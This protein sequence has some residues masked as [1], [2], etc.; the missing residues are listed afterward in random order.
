MA[1]LGDR[2]VI[3]EPP[4]L[5]RIAVRLAWSMS[6][7][8]TEPGPRRDTSSDDFLSTILTPGSSLNPK[9]LLVVDGVLASLALIL[10]SL[11]VASGGSLHPIALLLIELAL[12]VSI[13]W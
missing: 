9:F 12:W 2:A 8:H 3:S 1:V 6:I 4:P 10:V 5:H 11:I 7:H 13:K